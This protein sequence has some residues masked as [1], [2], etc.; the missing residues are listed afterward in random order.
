MKNRFIAE[1]KQTGKLPP[2]PAVSHSGVIWPTCHIALLFS[3]ILNMRRNTIRG[4]FTKKSDT[5]GN[6]PAIFKH[7][8][9]LQNFLMNPLKLLNMEKNELLNETRCRR[10][11][12][13]MEYKVRI[14][15][16]REKSKQSSFAAG[17]LSNLYRGLPW[18]P[19]P[20]DNVQQQQR[21]SSKGGI[22][23]LLP[24]PY[25]RCWWSPRAF[26]RI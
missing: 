15:S 24:F 16:T 19:G 12:S 22:C 2:I 23:L 14:I 10:P 26:H 4:L 9:V 17:G 1:F 25:S 11:C 8:E 20:A 3:N 5:K 6:M 21:H 7:D 18:E 13:Y